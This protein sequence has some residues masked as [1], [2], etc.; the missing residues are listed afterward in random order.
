MVLGA[1]RG[2]SAS[3]DQVLKSRELKGSDL[4]RHSTLP[5][6]YVY[7]PVE[8]FTTDDVWSYLLQVKNP[9]GGDN[10][11]LM[12]MYRSAS[13][14]GECPLVVDK[15]TPSCGNS[16][17]G[18]WVCP[19]VDRDHSM[20]SMVD[21][22]E[23]WMEPLLEFQRELA[24]HK[25]PKK[26]RK[27]REIKGRNGK[28]RT[29]KAKK[30][31]KKGARNWKK[32]EGDLMHGP[33]KFEVRKQMLRQLLEAQKAIRENGPD[34]TTC[35]IRED[36]LQVIRYMW[37]TELQDWED[38][39][40]KIFN[41]IIGEDEIIWDDE[42]VTTLKINDAKLLQE[43]CDAHD[44]PS[45]LVGKLVDLE[46]DMQ[47]MTKRAGIFNKIDKIFSEDWMEEKAVAEMFAEMEA[48]EAE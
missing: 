8:F 38:S 42:D 40:P 32:Q 2:E 34:P 3:R 13:S 6:S 14:D 20:E 4:R 48:V 31:Q 46:R 7:A 45:R 44:V 22:G 25:D 30:D 15:S 33:Y 18:C 43:I 12:G 11:V 36:E 10:Q 24:S 26:K 39:V 29:V 9:W 27:L 41:E 28:V 17:F 19:V 16:R 21:N 37:R 5:N 47:G 1:R 35:L 23:E